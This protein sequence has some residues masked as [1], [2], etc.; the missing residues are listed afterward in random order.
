MSPT[1]T[2]TKPGSA[3]EAGGDPLTEAA[4]IINRL[5]NVGGQ[6][7]VQ[8]M[9][10]EARDYAN[11]LE[12]VGK[13]LAQ[14]GD[15]LEALRREAA[16]MRALQD[17]LGLTDDEVEEVTATGFRPLDAHHLQQ[18]AQLREVVDRLPL[19]GLPKLEQAERVFTFVMR[20]VLLDN[21]RN[22][23]LLPPGRVLL[24][25]AGT[26]DER[27]FV[28]LSLLD[29][30][31]LQGCAV[32]CPGEPGCRLAGV[33]VPGDDEI[34]LFD[35]RL[36]VPLPGPKGERIATLR[37]VRA[38]P[39]L[40]AALSPDPKDPY[41]LDA[42]SFDSATVTMV[43]PLSALA[44][45]LR[46]VENLLAEHQEHVRL[47]VAPPRADGAKA[48]LTV[49]EILDRQAA[50]LAKAG[51]CGPDGIKVW[52]ARGEARR[53]PP[54]SPTRALRL[55]QRGGDG[56]PTG[57]PGQHEAF[58]LGL[59]PMELVKAQF[60]KLGDYDEWPRPAQEQL[61]VFVYD[62]YRKYVVFPRVQLCRGMPDQAARRLARIETIVYDCRKDPAHDKFL[63]EAGAWREKFT[64]AYLNQE[65]KDPKGAARVNAL[66]VEDQYLLSLVRV[67]DEEDDARRQKSFLSYFVMEAAAEPL[68]DEA[69]FL[70]ALSW[71]E[72][73]LKERA[74]LA[75]ENPEQTA[76]R[77][78]KLDLC[79]ATAEQWARE[80]ADKH[81]LTD[82]A[83]KA[84]LES[85]R[86]HWR[87]ELNPL[88]TAMDQWDAVF[89]QLRQAATARLFQARALRELGKKDEAAAVLGKLAAEV[90]AVCA[91]EELK[92][93]LARCIKTVPQLPREVQLYTRRRLPRLTAELGP[94]GGLTWLGRHARYLRERTSS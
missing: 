21:S 66:W 27:A 72:E 53:P 55:F 29:Q 87:P 43:L 71:Q 15:Q 18:C 94:D 41:D 48:S 49:P 76:G 22:E 60:R 32:Q 54:Q 75:D 24:R 93:E 88:L 61:L 39:R 6:L 12:L 33:L 28:F 58:Q 19:A 63:A 25:G 57:S 59:I 14:N 13:H 8:R 83:V 40:L 20:E 62:L 46:V 3:A 51:G 64:Q 4:T 89:R 38:Q 82:A 69:R 47:A 9:D 26:A 37:Q 78:A 35:P 34:Y 85:I 36:G 7:E 90:R 92:E 91:N 16:G 17:R 42:K 30:L 74:R 84:S 79:W 56:G 68:T 67:G 65:R 23:T 31:D 73:A 86:A 50:R 70:L 80:Y 10:G 1:T 52:N 45:R 77:K 5:H 81:P 2:A 44:P 11:V